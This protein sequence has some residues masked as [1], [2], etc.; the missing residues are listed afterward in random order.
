MITMG[1]AMVR[2]DTEE[3]DEV[4]TKMEEEVG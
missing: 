3:E 1:I 2:T 4:G